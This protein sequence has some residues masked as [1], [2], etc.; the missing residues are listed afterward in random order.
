MNFYKQVLPW[1]VV[2]LYS[3][4]ELSAQAHQSDVDRNASATY[5]G[6][7][8]VLISSSAG[9]VLFDPFFHNN[10]GSY[11]LV[12][13]EIRKAIFERKPPYDD[14]NIILISHAHGDHFSAE[15]TVRYLQSNKAV[16]LIA[17]KQAMAM[18]N[19]LEGSESLGSQLIPIA[20]AVGDA[21][22]NLTLG[23]IQIESV[24]IPHAGWPSRKDVSNL[25]HRVSFGGEFSVIHMG[26]ADPNDLHFKPHKK[27]WAKRINN[28]AF[29]PY[30]F[31]TSKQGPMILSNRLKA[32]HSVGVH[33]PVNTPSDLIES[34]ADFFSK[35]GEH[36]DINHA[37]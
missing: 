21:P 25:V 28:L 23:Q 15:D 14:I 35:P 20:L 18:I 16:T 36:R 26:D 34:G 12:P 4:T 5:L 1:I 31:Y 13:D 8:G 19:E 3:L 10:Y 32:E 30:W 2:V 17:P 11:Q 27:H 33:V 6:N 7:E 9:N 24:R 37:Q 29:P 22:E